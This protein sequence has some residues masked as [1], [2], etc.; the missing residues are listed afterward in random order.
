MK[1]IILTMLASVFILTG[2]TVHKDAIIK[3]NDKAI[4]QADFNSAYE[5]VASTGMLQQMKIQIPKDENN[6]MYLM[7]KDKV[8]NELI[9]KTLIDQEIAKRHIKVT[10]N[11]VNKELQTMI[12]KI[13]SKEQFNAI[14]KRNG[15]SNDQFMRDLKEE[16]RV[17]KL[18]NMVEN[19]KISD[20]TSEI[21]Y[22]KNLKLFS[23][24]DK[25]RATHILIMANPEEIMAKIKAQPESKD[26]TETVLN[27][28]VNAEMQLRYNKAKS[29][30]GRIK[31]LPDEFEKVAR[32]E[33]D[34]VES[35][36]N[37]GDLGFFAKSDMVEPF[38]TQAFT[39][40]V[41]T[42][43]PV[44]QTQYG[45]HIIKVT[46]RMV[47]GQEPFVKVKEQIKL[48]LQTKKQMEILDRIITQL[49]TDAKVEFVNESY[50]PNKI[51]EQIKEIQI[52]RQN[53][54]K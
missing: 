6:L 3:V 35:A 24:P 21:Y 43:G 40:Q 1:K 5:K 34:D 9:V 32:E 29:I 51:Q 31:N 26:L 20:K 50:N 4:T 47:A 42:V 18:V 27:E 46:D 12:D 7:L 22:K 23:Y 33:S 36:K 13:G 16:V 53:L 44:I 30:E 11:D 17:K 37:G 15:I 8:V 2:C 45:Y 48:Y 14:L 38:A 19:V 25:V 54:K 28:K 10:Q 39:Q 49:K 52:K 41:N